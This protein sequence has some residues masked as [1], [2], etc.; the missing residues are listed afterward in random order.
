[1]L[2]VL[3]AGKG[4][5]LSIPDMRTRHFFRKSQVVAA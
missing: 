4:H 5:L 2:D 3:S 1:M